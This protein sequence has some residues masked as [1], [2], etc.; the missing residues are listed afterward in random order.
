[1]VAPVR[2]YLAPRGYRVYANPDGSDYFDLVARRGA[3]LGLVELK[4]ALGPPTF[5]Q[6]LRR[7]R[8][9]DWVAVGIGSRRAAE[10]LV[11]RRAGRLTSGVGIWHVRPDGVDVL[12]EATPPPFPREPTAERTLLARYLDAVDAGELPPDVAWDGLPAIRR[13]LSSRRGYREWTIEES[14]P[15][16]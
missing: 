8:W 13:R 11:E 6:A 5:G 2:S 7:R 1:M 14:A 3:E 15:P 4:R 10:R 12:R 9:G 16:E